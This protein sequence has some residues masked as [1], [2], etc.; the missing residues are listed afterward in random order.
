M[1]LTEKQKKFAEEYVRDLNATRAYKAAFRVENFYLCANPE[2]TILD[3]YATLIFEDLAVRKY[4]ALLV[5]RVLIRPAFLSVL[6][7]EAVYPFSRD[8]PRVRKWTEVVKARGECKKC[9][10][11]DQ[12]EAHHIICWADFPLGRIDPSNGEC[13]CAACHAKEHR[14]EK[15]ERL[16][17]SKLKKGVILW[18]ES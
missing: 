17:R 14:G 3:A 5:L 16:I 12:L 4:A 8:D 18:E 11:N 1:A 6:I 2:E 13:L 10:A 15:A 7:D 9:G